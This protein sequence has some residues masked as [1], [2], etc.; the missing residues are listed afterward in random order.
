MCVAGREPAEHISDGDPHVADARTAT[1]LA[2]L[3]RNDVLIFHGADIA[4]FSPERSVSADQLELLHIL[5]AVA[6]AA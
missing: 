4:S 6:P 1:A 5:R 2:R 3:D